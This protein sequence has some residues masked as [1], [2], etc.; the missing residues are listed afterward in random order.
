[1]FQCMLSKKHYI[2]SKSKCDK[3][4]FNTG[5]LKIIFQYFLSLY[6]ITAW[7]VFYVIV[8]NLDNY[9]YIK[10]FVLFCIYY[11]LKLCAY[12]YILQQYD[13]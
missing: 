7:I 6:L 11:A 1:M 2:K 12:S 8:Y 10:C 5:V 4:G 9:V 13:I 3:N